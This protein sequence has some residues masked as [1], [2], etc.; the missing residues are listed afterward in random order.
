MHSVTVS[1]LTG[2][3]NS[4]DMSCCHQLHRRS[5]C[6]LQCSVFLTELLFRGCPILHACT[7]CTDVVLSCTD[8]A[9]P[10]LQDELLQKF[11]RQPVCYDGHPIVSV[12]QALLPS[13]PRKQAVQLAGDLRMEEH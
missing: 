8:V 1:S 12:A 11:F 5:A 10:A 7:E 9:V 2:L 3:R 13:L 6:Q 4:L